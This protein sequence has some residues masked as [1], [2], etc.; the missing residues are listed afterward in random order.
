MFSLMIWKL[1]LKIQNWDT[2]FI[3]KYGVGID[4]MLT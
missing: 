3:F 2:K 1:Y 4:L